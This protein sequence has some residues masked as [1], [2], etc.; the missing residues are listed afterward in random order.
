[1][2][3]RHAGV[4]GLQRGQHVKAGKVLR[5]T[6]VGSTEEL[7]QV[8]A[9][10]CSDDLVKVL[11]RGVG[12]ECRERVRELGNEIFGRMVGLGFLR[13]LCGGPVVFRLCRCVLGSVGF[14]GDGLRQFKDRRLERIHGEVDID[15]I[16]AFL[17]RF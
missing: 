4:D 9:L 6:T 7:E 2:F 8:V 10:V 3:Q 1:M 5:A 15:G 16:F 13:V 11:V 14:P 17:D 12:L